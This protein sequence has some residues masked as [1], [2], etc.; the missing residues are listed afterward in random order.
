MDVN[1]R[2][3]FPRQRKHAGVSYDQR[4]RLQFLKLPKIIPSSFQVIVMCQNIRSHIHFNALPMGKSNPLRHLLCRKIF[5]LGTQPESFAADIY[6]IR[7]K[8]NSRF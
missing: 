7:A 3:D 6:R 8:N 4:I 1:F 5:R 2:A